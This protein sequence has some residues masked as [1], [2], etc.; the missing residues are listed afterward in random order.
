M[1]EKPMIKSK[2]NESGQVI[3]IIAVGMVV[4]IGLVALAID[5]T[6]AYSERRN[7]QNAADTASFAAARAKVREEPWKAAGLAIANENSYTDTDPGNASSE[8]NSNV[9]IYQCDDGSKPSYASCDVNEGDEDYIVVAITSTIDT[10]FAPIVGINQITNRVK[11]VAWAN[12][13]PVIQ[14]E[15]GNAMLALMQGCKGESNWPHDPYTV[16]G[17]AN[18]NVTGSGIF[19]NSNCANAYT[20]NGSANVYSDSGICVVGTSSASNATSNCGTQLDYPPITVPNVS[21]GTQVAT[22]KQIA[23]HP[24]RIY[25]ATPGS[26]SGDFPPNGSPGKIIMTKGVYCIEDDFDVPSTWQITTDANGN[27]VFDPY[28]EGVLI[29]AVNGVIK[30]N[31]SSALDMHAISDS[32]VPEDLNNLLFYMPLG[33]T[34]TLSVN[35]GN[36][37]ELTGSIWAPSSHC[38]INGGSGTTINSQFVC[39]T[40]GIEGGSEAS[41]TYNNN[42]NHVIQVPP[43]IELSQ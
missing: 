20:Q 22:F 31:G 32:N 43:E 3:I 42:E 7:A 30:L 4:L 37:T 23:S 27:G 35:G 36:N 34:N 15:L 10:Y 1:R 13:D 12:L 14:N 41:I 39:F 5:G 17:N 21:C 9:E 25:L 16:G 24:D 8:A 33:N 11:A 19:I 38:S 28:T 6:N 2:K 26:W 29:M 18:L 40:I